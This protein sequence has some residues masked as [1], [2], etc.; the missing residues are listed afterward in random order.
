MTTGLIQITNL[1]KHVSKLQPLI[2]YTSPTRMGHGIHFES[3]PKK[4]FLQDQMPAKTLSCVTYSFI[5]TK[6]NAVVGRET[7][8]VMQ[9]PL[10][11]H[12]HHH[13]YSHYQD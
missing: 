8:V 2:Y 11:H 10:H 12:H 3:K 9:S 4:T 1:R 5:S 13:P 6:S 7:H